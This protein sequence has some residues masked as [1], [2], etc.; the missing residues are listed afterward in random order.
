MPDGWRYL[1]TSEATIQLKPGKLF[2]IKTVG[3]L[4]IVPVLN[5]S[6]QGYLGWHNEEPGVR[7]S[8]ENPVVTFANH[9]CSLRLML[10]PFSCIQNIFPKIGR[11]G[12]C[13]TRYFFY[14]A[15]ERVGISDYKGHHPLFRSALIPIPP[16][17]IQRRLASILGAYDDLIE[18]NRRRIAVLE[19]M[20]RRLFDEWFVHFRFPGHEGHKMVET[21][22]G[23]LPEGWQSTTLS[24]L[25][26]ASYGFTASAQDTVVGPKFVRVMDINKSDWISWHTVP[27]C[28]ISRSEVERYRLRVNDLVVARM[29]DPGKIG[30]VERE[31]DAIAAS[32]LVRLRPHAG[33]D[34]PFLFFLTKGFGYQSYV[35]GASTGTTRK[36]A[37]IPVLIGYRFTCPPDSLRNRF[38]MLVRPVREFGNALIETNARLAASRDLLLPRLISGDLSVTA[39]ERELETAA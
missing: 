7:A 19:E 34:A 36:S 32:Y 15:R 21:E 37:G 20:A 11:P 5:Q 27:H 3:A 12:I 24:S 17:P 10:R 25:V 30:F 8:E 26:E 13:D 23:R 9:T 14:A 38:A 2:E 39:A 6:E 35:S 22:H 18:V 31:I 16:R 29:A 28:V 1:S 33:A 4:G